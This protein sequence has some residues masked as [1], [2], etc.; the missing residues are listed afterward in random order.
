MIDTK[1]ILDNF[2][3]VYLA[4][5]GADTED[6]T[7]MD[8]L[9]EVTAQPKIDSESKGDFGGTSTSDNE[10]ISDAICTVNNSRVIAPENHR[11]R[12]FAGD[13]KKIILRDRRLENWLKCWVEYLRD[14]YKLASEEDRP[15]I[16]A[17]GEMWRGV[18]NEVKGRYSAQFR[19][20]KLE[21]NNFESVEYEIDPTTETVTLKY[22]REFLIYA[23]KKVIEGVIKKYPEVFNRILDQQLMPLNIA[24]AMIQ[25]SARL[26]R[27]AKKFAVDEILTFTGGVIYEDESGVE[28]VLSYDVV[29]MVDI[30]KGEDGAVFDG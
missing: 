10:K 25:E 29:L 11:K 28:Y 4:E 15:L 8:K 2:V 18:M 27:W 3:D 1:S 30:L 20:V 21:L 16:F 17:V 22:D 5:N 23:T 6:L 7:I 19:A 14:A 24:T 13:G 12:E 26:N 9:G